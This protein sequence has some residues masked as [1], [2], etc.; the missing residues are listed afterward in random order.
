MFADLKGIFCCKQSSRVPDENFCPWW[1]E[2][3]N[4][5]SFRWTSSH[6]R[7]SMAP[8]H[9][10]LPTCPSCTHQVCSPGVWSGTAHLLLPYLSSWARCPDTEVYTW[11]QKKTAFMQLYYYNI[12]ILAVSMYVAVAKM[13]TCQMSSARKRVIMCFLD[14]KYERR[15]CA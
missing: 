1:K 2:T 15:K 12:I 7:Q 11:A 6:D 9:L 5:N 4:E 14:E 3:N 8:I 13:R 10:H